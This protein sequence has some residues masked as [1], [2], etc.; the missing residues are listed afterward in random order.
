MRGKE[1]Q[2]LPVW[3]F[4]DYMVH[5]EFRGKKQTLLYARV[6]LPVSDC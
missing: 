2:I 3:K 1:V 6:N 4:G 5:L